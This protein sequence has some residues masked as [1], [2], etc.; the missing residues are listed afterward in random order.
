M[1]ALE[2]FKLSLGA[3]IRLSTLFVLSPLVSISTGVMDD[4]EGT[5]TFQSSVGLSGKAPPFVNGASINDSRGYV[6]VG[7][8]V[9]GHFDVFGK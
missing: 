6:T 7:V 4:T 8:G 3:E 2:F 9:G 5:T 1:T